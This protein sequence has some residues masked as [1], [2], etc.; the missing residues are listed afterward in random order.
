M[1]AVT[2]A[3]A[4]AVWRRQYLVWRKLIWS[5]LAT[6]VCNPL[7]F[8]F[9]FGFGL[10]AVMAE[11]EGVDYL[12]FVVP[13]M[14]CYSTMFVASFETTVSA[15][16]RYSMQRT[17]DATL[18]TSV[19]LEEMLFGEALWAASKAMLS[20]GCV[21]LVGGLWGGVPSW[22]GAAAAVPILFLAGLG[23]AA[24]GLLCTA[25]ARGFDAFGYFF[26]FWT[27]PMFVFSGVFFSLDRFPPLIG[28]AA[29]VLP[30]P[31]LLALIRPLT[32]GAGLEPLPAL[33][34]LA[35]LLAYFAIPFTVATARIRAR[36]FD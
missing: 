6:N 34:H 8:L 24:Q 31:H 2:L 1:R 28:T 9:A 19:T 33:G 15:F 21:M 10:G 27:T 23:F 16:A 14:M 20:A 5:S 29:W 4:G 22:A 12:A 30:M 3:A 13:G 7:L 36:M 32:T 26:T 25:F 35:V 11:Q 18:A 17:W